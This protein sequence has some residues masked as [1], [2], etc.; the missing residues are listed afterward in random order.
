MTETTPSQPQGG[1]DSTMKTVIV[2]LVVLAL[3]GLGL[4]WL[5]SN[6]A[7][8]PPPTE[9]ETLQP[10]D[11]ADTGDQTEEDMTRAKALAQLKIFTDYVN[12]IEPLLSEA[13]QTNLDVVVLFVETDPT[14]LLEDKSTFPQEVQDALAV[15]LEEVKTRIGDALAVVVDQ[16]S[17][18]EVDENGDP[19]E[20]PVVSVGD[21][22]TL[23][24]VLKPQVSDGPLGVFY[25]LVDENIGA[26][27]YFVFEGAEADRV[28][29][30]VGELVEVTVEI[31][32]VD[33]EGRAVLYK[34]V[35]GPTV[36]VTENQ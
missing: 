26:T 36:I 4:Y 34:V 8:S 32:Q 30:L 17:D 1:Q 11:G 35:D 15:V 28:A 13:G 10:E 25:T 23:E 27:F 2:I 20:T 31:T 5:S 7:E 21:V 14:V 3:G 19:V 33:E 29:D 18:D 24:G 22:V 6:S 12:V 16:P 9:E